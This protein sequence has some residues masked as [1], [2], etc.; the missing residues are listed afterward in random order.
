[1]IGLIKWSTCNKLW[2]GIILKND[3]SGRRKRLVYLLVIDVCVLVDDVH[4]KV[5]AKDI[6]QFQY[7]VLIISGAKPFFIVTRRKLELQVTEDLRAE[8]PCQGE[9]EINGA[10][11]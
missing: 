10:N 8:L 1:M 2:K 3:L 11:V 4:L 9:I 6:S 7:P 5:A